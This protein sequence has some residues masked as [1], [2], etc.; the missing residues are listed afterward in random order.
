MGRSFNADLNE[1]GLREK[2]YKQMNQSLTIQVKDI[3]KKFGLEFSQ[4]NPEIEAKTQEGKI[5]VTIPEIADELREKIQKE[6][7]GLGQRENYKIILA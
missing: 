7:N 3:L 1:P 5:F 6:L 4:I 2:L